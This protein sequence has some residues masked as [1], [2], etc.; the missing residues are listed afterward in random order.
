MISWPQKMTVTLTDSARVTFGQIGMGE[1]KLRV[2]VG[3][4]KCYRN[5]KDVVEIEQ[6]SP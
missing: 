1:E 2:G 4:E 5:K 6:S 3:N